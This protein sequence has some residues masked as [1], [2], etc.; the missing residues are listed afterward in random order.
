MNVVVL[1]FTE[2]VSPIAKAVAVL[3]VHPV[4]AFDVVHVCPA[5]PFLYKV[6]VYVVLFTEVFVNVMDVKLPAI[7]PA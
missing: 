7:P 4:P 6:Y 5:V 2:R 3:M 1:I